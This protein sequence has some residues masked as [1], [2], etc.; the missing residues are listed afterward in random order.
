MDPYLMPWTSGGNVRNNPGGCVSGPSCTVVDPLWNPIRQNIGYML[1][2]ANGKLDLAKMTPRPNLAST[3]R[4]LANAASTDAEYLVYTPSGG[5]FTVN[6]SATTRTLTVE[7]LNPVD[8]R[9]QLRR[10]GNRRFFGAVLHAAVRRGCG[11][12]SGGYSRES[13]TD[14]EHL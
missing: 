4:C 9:D 7:W 12:V 10:D 1:D 2:Y 13:A 8:G 14:G 5:S 11:V 3:G 6:L